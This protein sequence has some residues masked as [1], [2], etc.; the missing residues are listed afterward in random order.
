M[1]N[2]GEDDT[3]AI[4]WHLGVFDAHCHPTDTMS[5][6]STI[7]S[8]N[9]KALTIMA[10]RP[11]DQELV[12]QVAE[13]LG[14]N[15]KNHGKWDQGE[16]VVPSFGWHPWF[17][18]QLFDDGDYS[19]KERLDQDEKMRHYQSVLIPKPEDKHFLLALPD[20]RP[21]SVFIEETKQRLNSYPLALVGEIGID[22]SFRLPETWIPEHHD[23]RDGSLTP[24]GRE[25]RRLSPFRVDMDHQKKVLKAQLRLAGELGRAVSV[26]GV[27][28][29]GVVFDTLQETWKG[30]ERKV[31]SRRDRK[32][33]RDP[34]DA[35]TANRTDG[36][37]NN[38]AVPKP[39]P[40]RICLHSYSGPVEP[41]KQYL[42]PSVP[43]EVFF[44]FSIVINFSDSQHSKA[45]DVIKALPDDRVL[46]ESDI[47]TAGERMDRFLAEIIRKVCSLKGWDLMHGLEQLRNNY[48]RFAFGET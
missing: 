24:G 25:G 18:H 4:P 45:E 15:S 36:T 3:E 8:M 46:V 42:S 43:A 10:T 12:R 33:R 2:D 17:S 28:A 14:I 21:L 16:K 39:Y 31:L 44:S 6:I 35:V 27:Q 22:K 20:P 32:Q 30:H 37:N 29:H 1:D 11:E 40:P 5:S 38:D 9:A 13:E 34:G 41:I 26:H 19:G 23:R 7:R 48:F 47:H